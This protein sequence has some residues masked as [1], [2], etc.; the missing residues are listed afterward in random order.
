[1]S[2]ALYAALFARADGPPFMK[3]A[4]LEF[5]DGLVPPPSISLHQPLVAT[6]VFHYAGDVAG[7]ARLFDISVQLAT[8]YIR[9]GEEIHA[10]QGRG[11]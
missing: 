4:T 11:H 2:R 10:G 3:V 1:V 7:A 8:A 6:E 9:R 5:P